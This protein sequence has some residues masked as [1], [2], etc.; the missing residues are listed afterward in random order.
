MKI[1]IAGGSGYIGRHLSAILLKHGHEVV[2]LTRRSQPETGTSGVRFVTWDARTADGAWVSELAGADG[3]VNLAG[4]SIGAGRWTRRRM[5]EILSSRLQA[6]RAIVQ[7][8]ERTA[9]GRRPSVLVNASGIDYY[10]DRGDEPITERSSVGDSFLARVC[11]QWEAAANQA[12]PLGV[13]VVLIRTALV[14]GRGAVAFQLLTLPFRLFVGG[15]LGDGRQWF[16]WIHVD[17]LVELYRLAL[18]DPRVS[19]PINAV[20]P[21]IRPQ[22]DTAQRIG[23]ALHR[24]AFFPAPAAMLRLALGAQADLLLHGRRA[25]PIKAQELGFRFRFGD[26][27]AALHDILRG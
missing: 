3:L 15:P 23:H 4:A 6:T 19:G 26:V 9:P 22:R 18:D 2:V 16:T 7:G 25:S 5:A 1:L 14:F 8:I 10:G 11:Q 12:G 20:A 24:P 21:D 17:D 27:D 13:R